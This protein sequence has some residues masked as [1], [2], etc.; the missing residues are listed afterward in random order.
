MMDSFLQT[1]LPAIVWASFLAIVV[2]LYLLKAGQ[3]DAGER[4]KFGA[5]FFIGLGRML[6][7][8]VA[9][10]LMAIGVA[11]F[12]LGRELQDYPV[13]DGK[14]TISVIQIWW[15][16]PDSTMLSVS[17]HDD[18]LAPS[19]ELVNL[20]SKYWGIGVD[21]IRWP[22]WTKTLGLM[23]I[24]RLTEML[25]WRDAAG[26]EPDSSYMFTYSKLDFWEKILKYGTYLDGFSLEK[27]RSRTI[28]ATE[29]V[30][31]RAAID[32]QGIEIWEEVTKTAPL[33]S[34]TLEDSS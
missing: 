12:F 18:P 26:A 8:L 4:H 5:R 14:S 22:E 30:I 9:L 10:L 6:K 1:D 24:Y 33:L 2:G 3:K 31:Y 13:L 7:F 29:G 27:M 21:V 32:H 25:S 19:D 17:R 28:T 20:P 11:S 15:I 23:P 16:A 34:A